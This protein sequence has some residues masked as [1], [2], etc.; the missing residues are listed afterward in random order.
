MTA[1]FDLLQKG[2]T[3]QNPSKFNACEVIDDGGNTAGCGGITGFGPCV[4]AQ[5]RLKRKEMFEGQKLHGVVGVVQKIR[6]ISGAK[7]DNFFR[8]QAVNQFD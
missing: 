6:K 5:G 8:A 2:P 4:H 7:L 3:V 1:G